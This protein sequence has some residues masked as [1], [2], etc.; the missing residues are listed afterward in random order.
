VLRE[1]SWLLSGVNAGGYLGADL[2]ISGTVAAAREGVLH[3]YPGIAF[4]HYLKKGVPIDW[5][6]AT[7]WTQRV[8]RDLLAR[9]AEPGTYWSVNLPHLPANAPEPEIVFCPAD[10]SPLPLSFREEDGQ[11]HYDGNYHNRKRLPG[12][13]VDVCFSGRIAVSKLSLF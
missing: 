13:D 7:H 8:L 4:S 11:F 12:H 6:L 3:G 5:G 9:P 10:P 1:P 2:H